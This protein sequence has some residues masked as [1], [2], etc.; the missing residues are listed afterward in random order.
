MRYSYCSWL[1]EKTIDTADKQLYLTFIDYR[2]AFDM[3]NHK[4]LFDVIL[5]MEY[6]DISWN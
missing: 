3:V 5:S 2:K 4:K 6:Q 1:I